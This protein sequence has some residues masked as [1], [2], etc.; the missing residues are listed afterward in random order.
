VSRTKRSLEETYTVLKQEAEALGLI[1]NQNKTKYMKCTRK[2][3][4]LDKIIKIGEHEIERVQEFKYLGTQVNVHNIM[5][6][7]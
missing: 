1:I 4:K 7:K 2:K 5:K 6:E 3:E